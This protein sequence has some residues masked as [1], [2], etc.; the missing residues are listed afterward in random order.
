MTTNRITDAKLAAARAPHTNQLERDIASIPTAAADTKTYQLPL[1]CKRTGL[2]VGQLSVVAVA[3]H[4][5]MMGQWKDSMVLHPLF[6]LDEGALVKFSRN[7]W[8]RFCAFNA[9]ESID[10]SLT[11]KQE[12]LLRVAALAMLHKLTEFR[13]DQSWL[14]SWADTSKNWNSLLALSYWKNYLESERFRFPSLRISKLEPEVDLTSYLQ[15]CWQIKKDYETRVSEKIERE[16]VESAEKALRV[17]RDDLAG[18]APRSARLLWRWFVANLPPRYASDV[19]GYMHK[20]FW[21]DAEWLINEEYTIADMDVFEQIFLAECPTGN[22]LSHAFLNILKAK[23]NEFVNHFQTFEIMIP[24]I[25]QEQKASGE[26]AVA[27]PQKADYTNKALYMIAHA[28]WKLAHKTESKVEAAITKSNTVTVN[29]SFVPK[30]PITRVEKAV[31]A[32]TEDD[33]DSDKIVSVNGKSYPP[34]LL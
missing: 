21:K 12:T 31:A 10:D 11:T 16:K 6:S 18:K 1:I 24:S 20:L 32:E 28:K 22:S 3:G 8:F 13:Q 15:L 34:A 27:E 26:I 25:I 19:E 2:V 4:Y 5:P 9:E 29:P 17:L 14:P 33:Y 30:L 23:R 7:A